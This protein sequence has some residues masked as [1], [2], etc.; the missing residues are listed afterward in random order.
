MTVPDPAGLVTAWTWLDGASLPEAGLLAVAGSTGSL[1][2]A[3]RLLLAGFGTAAVL[4]LP[5][6]LDGSDLGAVQAWL[7]AVPATP[8]GAGVAARDREAAAPGNGDGGS[9][10]DGPIGRAV[11]IGALPFDRAAPGA[12]VVPALTVGRHRD[13]RAWAT[14]VAAADDAGPEAL[15]AAV[16]ELLDRA[17]EAEQGVGQEAEQGAEGQADLVAAGDGSAATVPA[18][19]LTE[20]PPGA[21]YAAAVAEA[22][23][24]I[25]AGRLEKV[26][27]ARSLEA[28]L[29]RPVD[30]GRVVR[31]LRAQEPSCTTFSVP[32]T[33][34]P[35][36]P[37]G[38]FVGASPE[39]LVRRAG[40]AVTCHPLA[41]TIGLTGDPAVDAA[42]VDRFLAS[43]KEHREHRLVVDA[44]A[45]VLGPLTTALAAPD[46]P[47]LVRL[48]SVAHFG[49]VI[50]GTLDAPG[51]RLP[52][53]LDLLA[54]LH[55]TP[56]VG[57]VPRDRALAAIA[58]LEP[59]PRGLWAGP[60]GWVDGKGDGEWMIGLRSATVDGD[61]VRLHA[62][63]GV[64]AG[65]DPAAELAET[66]VKLAPMLDA[67]AP[68]L[69]APGAPV[70]GIP[71][72]GAP[73]PGAQPP[74]PS[75]AR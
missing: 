49:T 63:A 28:R 22:V 73:A 39:L 8:V 64:V 74:G 7:A 3:D 44:I 54:A 62:G 27:L 33:P 18:P 48:Q 46:Q 5:G 2:A 72:P 50:D 59:A 12:L 6:G 15:Q 30:L 14:L 67:L 35:A 68:G 66:T 58:E 37:G 34:G 38:R 29:G 32:T 60:V 65:S 21:G 71:V 40:R 9:D 57:G 56:A 26:V 36:T 45:A 4:P 52:S 69:L 19:A 75:A 13:G 25:E 31:R 10:G 43:A 1:F 55:P 23:A 41:G 53:V 42:T 70:P 24:E 16:A 61:V 20:I 51:G 47:S 17:R 11:A